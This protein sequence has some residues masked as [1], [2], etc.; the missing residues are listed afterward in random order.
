M[1]GRKLTSFPSAPCLAQV[2][3]CN[4]RLHITQ[5]IKFVIS[6]SALSFRT[7]D[8]DTAKTVATGPI[9]NQ[10]SVEDSA[11][12]DINSELAYHL[13]LIPDTVLK[14]SSSGTQ[15]H[16]ELRLITALSET[17]N[18]STQQPLAH[19]SNI[20][21]QNPSNIDNFSKL[22]KRQ[23]LLTITGR[24]HAIK[25]NPHRIWPQ[26]NNNSNWELFYI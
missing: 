17:R 15:K 9:T 12:V 21:L 4:A 19:P 24:E 16:S 23:I 14:E 2:E 13:H 3:D 26:I 10:V 8:Y 18:R 22:S 5:I 20:S 11:A 25:K 6:G 1:C 7:N